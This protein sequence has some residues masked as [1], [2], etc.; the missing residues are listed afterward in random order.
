MTVELNEG[1][2]QPCW[3]DKTLWAFLLLAILQGLIEWLP[4]SSEGQSVLLLTSFLGIDPA[5]AVSIALWLHIGTVGAVAV[6]YRSDFLG[7]IKGTTEESSKLRQFL[8][9]STIATGILGV[10]LYLLIMNSFNPVYGDFAML[11]V[12]VG[13][14][15]TGIA[16]LISRRMFGDRR[17]S[18]MSW[19]DA[20]IIGLVQGLT[21]LPGISRSGFTIAALLWRGYGQ[22]ESLKLSFMMSV[23]A[24]L[25]GVILDY[26]VY[27]VPTS[28]ELSLVTLL[29]MILVA[30]AIGFLTVGGLTKLSRRINFAYFCIILGLIATAI[31]MPVLVGGG[32]QTILDAIVNAASV[33]VDWLINLIIIIGPIGFFAVMIVQAVAAPIPS[34]AIIMFGGGAFFSLYGFWTGLLM[35]GLI[36]GLGECA[37]ALCGFYISRL[38][39]RPIAL[40]LIGERGIRFADEWFIKWGGWAVLIGRLVPLIPFDAVSYGAGLTKMRFRSFLIAT[41]VGAFPRAFF[42]GYLGILIALIGSTSGL[43]WVYLIIGGLI[44]AIVTSILIAHYYVTKRY[45]GPEENSSG[46]NQD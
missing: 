44:A 8:L 1:L 11:V 41:A 28:A 42:Y 21:I 46:T 16:L 4:I 12:G 36:G 15:I 45:T 29:I 30:F 14:I 19:K 2:G 20:F 25:A 18:D 40:R 23:P 10:P 34:E 22:S 32:G 13:L 6:F 5:M 26:T 9:I 17:I 27:G 39:G 24:V 38:G 37:G 3:K 43:E 33:A 35:T 7:V 31:S